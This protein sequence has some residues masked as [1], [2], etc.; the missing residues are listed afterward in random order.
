[1]APARLAY[2]ERVHV[3]FQHLSKIQ[4]TVAWRLDVPHYQTTMHNIKACSFPNIIF[5][6]DGIPDSESDGGFVYVSSELSE[7]VEEQL[8]SIDFVAIGRRLLS[9]K[10][11]HSVRQSFFEDFGIC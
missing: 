6:R 3:V 4:I 11:N 5:Y 9:R 1:M 7:E 2:I 8:A 10:P